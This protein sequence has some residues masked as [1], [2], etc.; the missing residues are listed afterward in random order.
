MGRKSFPSTVDYQVVDQ[1]T[2][3]ISAQVNMMQI[4]LR[5]LFTR[6]GEKADGTVP[7]AYS[8]NSWW[9]VL[10]RNLVDATS[11]FDFIGAAQVGVLV[12]Q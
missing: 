10:I 3:S 12:G 11:L 1:F 9:L 2:Y 7:S 4:R 5:R 8:Q 6:A